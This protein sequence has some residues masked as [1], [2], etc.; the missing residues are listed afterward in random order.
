MD[1]SA[2]E[3]HAYHDSLLVQTSKIDGCIQKGMPVSHWERTVHAEQYPRTARQPSERRMYSTLL[4]N[5]FGLQ[6]GE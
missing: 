3:H 2:L 1:F 6:M 4:K 5:F